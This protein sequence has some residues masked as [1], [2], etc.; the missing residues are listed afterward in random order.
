MNVSE[1]LIR[2]SYTVEEIAYLLKAEDDE[3]AMLF[4]KAAQVKEMHVQNKVYFRG[5]IEFSNRC[6]KNCLYC[7]IRRDNTAG[8]TILLS[9]MRKSWMPPGLPL[10]TVMV[11]LCCNR[12][13]GEGMD[14]QNGLKTC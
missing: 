7:G 9:P 13:K 1:I 8:Q 14:L 10:R 6:S 11:P 4:E 3:K 5:L 12:V 2:D